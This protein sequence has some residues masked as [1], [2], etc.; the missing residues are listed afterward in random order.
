MKK[1]L[2]I[3][4]IFTS[5]IDLEEFGGEN[6]YKTGIK[7]VYNDAD[8][9]ADGKDSLRIAV[10]MPR[11]A[12]EEFRTVKF[13]ASQGVFFENEKSE[14]VTETAFRSGSDS[15]E[16]IAIL[17]ASTSTENFNLNI[18]IP[19]L[20]ITNRL[21]RPKKSYPEAMEINSNKVKVLNDGVDFL[22]ISV[23]LTKDN[24]KV[25][26]GHNVSFTYNDTITMDNNLYFKNYSASDSNGVSSI[27]FYPYNIEASSEPRYITVSTETSN[28][29]IEEQYEFVISE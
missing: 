2:F 13:K 19:E 24:G 26:Q 5:C 18:Q 16:F 4:I 9:I 29:L 10:I 8:F 1:Y 3:L 21:V 14:Y 22:E 6:Y 23:K 17:K 15:I 12:N 25:T 7:V 27:R 28:G 20:Y 11:E